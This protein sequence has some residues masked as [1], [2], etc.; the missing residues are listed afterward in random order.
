MNIKAFAAAALVAITAIGADI[1]PAKAGTLS[2]SEAY[3]LC[4]AGIAANR[5]GYS[6]KPMLQQVFVSRGAPAY[7]ANV[8]LNEMKPYCPR[9]Y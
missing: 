4:Q 6:V 3:Q 8:A 5:E 9:V 1:A 7:L 2:S